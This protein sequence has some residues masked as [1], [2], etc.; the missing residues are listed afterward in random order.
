MFLGRC[1]E[2]KLAID[3]LVLQIRSGPGCPQ[4]LPA[5]VFKELDAQGK[6]TRLKV[7]VARGLLWRM[8]AVVFDNQP[9]AN[10]E[11]AAIVGSG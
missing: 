2:Q 4:E 8:Q 6:Q 3:F 9:V 1:A 5:A 11:T 7:N 10:V